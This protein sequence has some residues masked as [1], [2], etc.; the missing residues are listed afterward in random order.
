MILVVVG[1]SP[2]PFD[3]LVVEMDRIAGQLKEEVLIQT[4]PSKC[5]LTN[6]KTRRFLEMSEIEE[7]MKASAVVVS[8]AGMGTVL[9]ARRLRKP[10]VI[11]PR[12]KKLREALDN[13]QTSTADNLRGKSGIFV[14][15]SEHEL[16]TLIERAR[17]CTIE[18]TD[19][20]R[21]IQLISFL[22]ELI[23]HD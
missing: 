18:N 9:D 7:A 13:H 21:K 16:S 15:D 17:N 23:D 12:R 1:M 14:A 2:I 19:D 3:R 22:R 6:A 11:L 5:S 8:H 20:S 10:I 4:G